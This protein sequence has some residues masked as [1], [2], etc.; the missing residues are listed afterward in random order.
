MYHLRGFANT[1]NLTYDEFMYTELNYTNYTTDHLY[2]NNSD[3]LI[4]SVAS[5]LFSWFY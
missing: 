4:S 5:W 1:T 3:T 2:H